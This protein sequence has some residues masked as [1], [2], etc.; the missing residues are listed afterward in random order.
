MASPSMSHGPCTSAASRPALIAGSLDAHSCTCPADAALNTK[1]P[2]STVS[3]L[4]GPATYS[5]CSACSLRIFP[6]C[7]S[8]SFSP[9]SLLSCGAFEGR[10]SSTKKYCPPELSVDCA[11]AHNEKAITATRIAAHVLLF[12][13]TLPSLFRQF[14][15]PR[16]LELSRLYR[17][18]LLRLRPRQ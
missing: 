5:L 9:S 2:R 17:R 18:C 3:S 15:L 8:C 16:N 12:F 7:A 6:I 11:A 14:H 1:I 10:S 13:K 4:N